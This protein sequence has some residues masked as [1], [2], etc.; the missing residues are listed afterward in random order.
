MIPSRSTHVAAFGKI[1]FMA[2]YYSIA[3]LILYYLWHSWIPGLQTLNYT[4]DFSGSSDCRWQVVRFL[5][6]QNCVSQ[7]YNKS[8]YLSVLFLWLFSP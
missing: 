1:F 2:E 7:F 5:S 8:T 6:F 4:T 3:T